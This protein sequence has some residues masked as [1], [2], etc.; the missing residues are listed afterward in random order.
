MINALQAL[1]IPGNLETES[2]YT[3]SENA[4]EEYDV[5]SVISKNISVLLYLKV[6]GKVK[7]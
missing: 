6:F 4:I 5:N 7:L 2:G 3:L 1:I